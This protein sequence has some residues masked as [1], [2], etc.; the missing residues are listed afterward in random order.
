MATDG[1]QDLPELY[2]AVPYDYAASAPPGSLL[3]TAGACPLDAEGHV[4]GVGDHHEQAVASLRNLLAVL[5][6]HGAGPADLVRTTIYVVGEH[7]DLVAGWIGSS[8]RSTSANAGIHSSS[9]SGSIRRMRVLACPR[10]CCSCLFGDGHFC[11]WA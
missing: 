10:V 11:D 3:F 9:R 2:D 8:L 4:V 7:T 6:R 5:D 1:A